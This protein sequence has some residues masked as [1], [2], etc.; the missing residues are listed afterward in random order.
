MT[1]PGL[2]LVPEVTGKIVI[3]CVVEPPYG[4]VMVSTG[5]VSC[6]VPGTSTTTVPGSSELA[7]ASVY[8]AVSEPPFICVT[9]TNGP[10]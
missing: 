9:V 3:V 8:V 7:G 4:C 6:W 2:V 10:E 5:P 1:L